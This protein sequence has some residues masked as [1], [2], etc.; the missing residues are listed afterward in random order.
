MFIMK[1]LVYKDLDGEEFIYNDDTG[2]I[3]PYDPKLLY[4]ME[5]GGKG[6]G[7]SKNTSKAKNCLI[8]KYSF[9]SFEYSSK[10]II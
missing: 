1:T 7:G 9:S 2:M 5:H 4:S 10:W 8:I 6:M 3:F